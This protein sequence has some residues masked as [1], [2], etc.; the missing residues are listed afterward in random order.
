[1][2][3]LCYQNR[4]ILRGKTGLYSTLSKWRENGC[5]VQTVGYYIVILCDSRVPIPIK[6]EIR[7][8]T[9]RKLYGTHAWKF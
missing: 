3:F 1:M 9:G 5:I 4:K 7:F 6:M 2:T 8:P